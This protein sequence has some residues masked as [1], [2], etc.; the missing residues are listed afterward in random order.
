MAMFLVL[1]S[2]GLLGITVGVKACDFSLSQC[3]VITRNK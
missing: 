3:N 2:W 1:V